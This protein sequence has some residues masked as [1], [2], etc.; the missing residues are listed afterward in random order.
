MAFGE[1]CKY[2]EK[3]KRK[4]RLGEADAPHRQVEKGKGYGKI[5]YKDT[6]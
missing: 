6:Y 4:M 5:K 2:R 1:R 3:I